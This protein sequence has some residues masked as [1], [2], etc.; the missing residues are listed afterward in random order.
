MTKQFVS[1]IF[2]LL[3][4]MNILTN[5]PGYCQQEKRPV[6]WAKKVET[7]QVKNLWKLND[8]IYRSAQPEITNV[9]Y[10]EKMGI[11]GFLDLRSHH[12]DKS[13]VT[14]TSISEYEVEMKADS[15]TDKEIIDALRVIKSSS[16]PLLIHCKQGSD[17][18]GVV[19]AMY[20]IIFQG[21]TKDKA[22]TELLNGG[23]G[24]HTKYTNIPFYIKNVDIDKIKKSLEN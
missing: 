5:N 17:R 1:K 22:L 23:Y 2:F 19:I 18:T 20:R 15:F 12:S 6:D 13:I 9:Q 3:L 10:L 14:G 21:W 24:F 7:S 16:K 4:L 8:T 11:H